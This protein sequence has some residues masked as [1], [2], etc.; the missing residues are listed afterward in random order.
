MAVDIN[1][2][3]YLNQFADEFAKAL[4]SR[5]EKTFKG[6]S[7][8]NTTKQTVNTQNTDS[9]KL[10]PDFQRRLITKFEQHHQTLVG[11]KNVLDELVK[12]SFDLRSNP[13]PDKKF[14][15]VVS[16]LEKLFKAKFGEAA[17]TTKQPP[18]SVP[19]QQTPPAVESKLE[20]ANFVQPVS[21][22][23]FSQTSLEHLGN[24]LT[25]ILPNAI[26]EGMKG[27]I[28]SIEEM[29]KTLS[30][31][32]EDSAYSP[33]LLDYLGLGGGGRGG[34]ARG[35]AKGGRVRGGLGKPVVR[36]G[37]LARG[38]L[39]RGGGL[40][41][42]LLG[43]AALLA[44]PVL[45]VMEYG[46]RLDE[47]QT[48]TQ[49]VAGATG[50]AAGGLAGGALGFKGGAAAGGAI[51]AL[52][53][54]VGA[55]PGAAIGGAIGLIGGGILGSMAGGSLADKMSGVGSKNETPKQTTP[56]QSLEKTRLVQYVTS[57]GRYRNV[58]EFLKAVE[59]GKEPRIKWNK[60]KKVW[61]QW[62]PEPK[63]D[64]NIFTAPPVVPKPVQ[65]AVKDANDKA[66]KTRGEA[67]AKRDAKTEAPKPVEAATKPIN[68]DEGLMAYA[69]SPESD[70]LF[71]G[72]DDI[73][74]EMVQKRESKKQE[75]EEKI[76]QIKHATEEEKL[77]LMPFEE[78]MGSKENLEKHKIRSER[79]LKYES[80]QR[81][82]EKEL[83]KTNEFLEKQNSDGIKAQSVQDGIIENG[84]LK[85]SAPLGQLFEFSPKDSGIVAPQ[86]TF[87][88]FFETF[89]KSASSQTIDNK[90]LKDT[91][92]EAKIT[93]NKLDQLAGGF[94]A[95]A[96][97]LQKL[98]GNLS[99]QGSTTVINAAGESS[100]QGQSG[101]IA[102]YINQM[103]DAARM[104]T[105]V[106][107][108]ATQV[109]P[110]AF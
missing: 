29:T 95:M 101:G 72:F 91:A 34:K 65:D 9:S 108:Y 63:Y 61:E 15:T 47:G 103:N 78:A 13:Q 104:Y 10:V 46:Q 45:G 81:R 48:R 94:Q 109:K 38:L 87:D 3:D 30:D 23:E 56:E 80:E 40:A 57:L 55:I 68:V 42:G 99:E 32:I 51:G 44:T 105:G 16:N 52:F 107:G 59:V 26:K 35:R 19:A 21:I 88:K 76:K 28:S 31:S 75:V 83:Q 50:S 54:G 70:K 89:E 36:G 64:K 39:G 49:A 74:Q 86:S 14:P 41:R 69:A 12:K 8:E 58:D 24:K 11:I 84:Q 97:A 43:P 110:P 20:K 37:G 102:Q 22:E 73:R 93:N 62:M 7:P 53:G 60:E 82:L 4:L 17:P 67:A 18:A 96:K 27:F 25:D 71:E 100:K 85:R 33:G 79:I 6:I 77:Q 66:P 2:V 5:V 90:A 98:G 106:G 92:N 1:T